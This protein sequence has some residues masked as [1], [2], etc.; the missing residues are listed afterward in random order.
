MNKIIEVIEKVQKEFEARGGLKNVCFTAC[1]GSLAAMYS[2]YYLLS[3]EAVTFSCDSFNS[4]EFVH[5]LPKFVGKNSL[6]I[7]TSTKATPE[8][9][10]AIKTAN[11]AGAVTIGL[12][13]AA[14]S[15]TASAAMY[16]I[17]YNHKDQWNEDPSLVVTNSQ[18]TA[19]K[20]AF[21]LLHRYE[22]YAYYDKALEA[23]QAMGGIYREASRKIADRKISFALEY[24]DDEVFN[25]IGSGNL[26]ATAYVD[27]VC[28]LQEMQQRHAVTVHGGEY[29]HGP[30]ETTGKTLPIILLMGVGR[31]RALDERV[32]RF[33]DTFGGRVTIID[34]EELGLARLDKNIAEYFN[35]VLIHPLTKQY[36]QEMAN[37]RQ[38]PMSYRR[39]MWKTEY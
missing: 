15:L 2:A 34:A 3:R 12:T 37:I 27:S 36:I 33:L 9:V 11:A 39:Y 5:T 10:E 19:L 20:I 17:V 28:F 35:G 31:T 14:D 32:K 16:S 21:E 30:F 7:G 24:Q 1:G 18:S 22:N 8:T 26:Y 4:S 13:G 23:F 38:H 6:V 25:V 29:F